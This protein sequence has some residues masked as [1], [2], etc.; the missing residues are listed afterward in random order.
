MLLTVS[1]ANRAVFQSSVQVRICPAALLVV[2]LMLIVLFPIPVLGQQVEEES[3]VEVVD[4][5]P[6][7]EPR[8]NNFA[9]SGEHPK[10]GFLVINP[11]TRR[12][13]Q[14][15]IANSGGSIGTGTVIWSFDLDSLEPIRRV[16]LQ[17]FV[18]IPTGFGTNPPSGA[19]S[20]APGDVVHAVDGEGGRLF[21]ASTANSVAVINEGRFD[22]LTRTD[23]VEATWQIPAPG[24]TT[25]VGMVFSRM[26]LGVGKLL[27][28]GSPIGATRITL[29]GSAGQDYLLQLN[30]VNGGLDWRDRKSVV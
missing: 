3:L 10:D 5:V 22:D 30:T 25:P 11:Q 28:V 1:R 13:Y 14:I 17:D 7:L 4:Q 19:G 26:E 18:T 6:L 16:F 24:V 20:G 23:F 9:G 29:Q 12:G 2:S 27:I 21:L 8:R 15:F